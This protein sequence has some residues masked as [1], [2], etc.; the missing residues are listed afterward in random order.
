MIGKN[1]ERS[2]PSDKQIQEMYKEDLLAPYYVDGPDSAHVDMVSAVSLLCR[3]CVTLS[4][5]LYTLYQPIFYMK[6][7]NATN[8]KYVVYIELPT[9]CPILEPVQV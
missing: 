3:Y 8:P 4:S 6:K 9:A 1:E 7:I 2:K 5:D